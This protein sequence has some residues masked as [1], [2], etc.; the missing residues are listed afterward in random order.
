M[1]SDDVVISVRN[2]TKT[3]RMFAHPGDRLKQTMT[4]GLRKYHKAFTALENVSFDVKKGEVVGIIGRN[5]SGKST[6]LQLICGILK[7]TSGRVEVKGKVSALLELGA[8]FNP[9][10]TGRENVYFQGA[11]MGMSR[12]EIGHRFK[13]IAEFAD[14]GEFIDQ[15]VRT[16]SSGMFVRLAFSVASHVDA[17]ILIIDEAL[18][19]GDLAFQQ[20]CLEWI[21]VLRERGATVVLVSHAVEQVAHHCQ[22][23]FLID[24]GR[25][26]ADGDTATTLAVY[27]RNLETG[28]RD[29]ATPVASPSHYDARDLIDRIDVHPWYTGEEIRWG[30]GGARIV[31]ARVKQ[32]SIVSPA[33]VIVGLPLE[34]SFEVVFITPVVHPIFGLTIKSSRGAVVYSDNSRELGAQPRACVTGDRVRA[35]FHITPFLDSG[36]YLLSFGI[37][38]AASHGLQPHDRRYDVLTMTIAAPRLSSGKLDLRAAF[39][40]EMPV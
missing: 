36:R 33:N 22:T 6:L 25:L 2:L 32:G 39:D 9:E 30:D 11:L 19:V 38:S 28:T 29:T 40:L 7:P 16:Y 31:D 12:E 20:K 24:N 14:I 8:G 17:D 10:F 26:C 1:S 3:Y 4:L 15:P 34:I 18:A 23:A 37:V 5:G 27:L 21:D 13:D 35:V